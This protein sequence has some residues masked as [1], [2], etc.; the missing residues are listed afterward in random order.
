MGT[1]NQ[2]AGN[3]GCDLAGQGLVGGCGIGATTM[4]QIISQATSQGSAGSS[5]AD[6]INQSLEEGECPLPGM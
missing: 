5:L 4:Q 6:L 3:T 1:N 2:G